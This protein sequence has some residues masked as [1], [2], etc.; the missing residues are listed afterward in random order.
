VNIPSK[1][2][3]YVDGMFITYE[4][5][6]SKQIEKKKPTHVDVHNIQLIKS[7]KNLPTP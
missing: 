4:V 2:M 1:N 5:S 7:L 3:E 6:P